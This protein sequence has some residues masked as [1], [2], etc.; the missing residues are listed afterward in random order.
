MMMEYEV[1]DTFGNQVVG[2]YKTK[3]IEYFGYEFG[4]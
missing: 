4:E 1:I 3:D 2:V